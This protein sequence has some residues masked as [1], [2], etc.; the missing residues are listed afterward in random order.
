MYVCT[1]SPIKNKTVSDV[2]DISICSSISDAAHDSVSHDFFSPPTLSISIG[3]L[4]AHSGPTVGSFVASG[5]RQGKSMALNAMRLV[6]RDGSMVNILFAA[7]RLVHRVLCVVCGCCVCVEQVPAGAVG[8][9][10]KQKRIQPD[11]EVTLQD[12]SKDVLLLFVDGSNV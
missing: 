3:T 4:S 10:V 12:K 8:G 5:M 7:R 9:E 11:K 2:V 1:A 6:L